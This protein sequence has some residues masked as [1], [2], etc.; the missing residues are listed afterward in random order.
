[1]INDKKLLG[2]QKGH[3]ETKGKQKGCQGDKRPLRRQGHRETK[4]EIKRPLRR[5]KGHRETKRPL[6]RQKGH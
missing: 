3:K 6:G 4:G 2:T 5:Q 1:M